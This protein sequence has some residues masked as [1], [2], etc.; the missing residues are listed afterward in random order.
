MYRGRTCLPVRHRGV[1]LGYVWLLDTDPG[2]S[3]RQLDG[4]HGGRGADR[5]AARRRGAAR[6]GPEPG[7]AG[8]ADRRAGAGSGTW[9]WRNCA[10]RWA[11]GRTPRTRWSVWRPG[12]Q[13]TRTTRPRCVRCRGRRP[14]AR[15]R[16]GPRPCHSRCWSGCAPAHVP[17]PATAA[18][19]RLLERA[20]GPFRRGRAG[21]RRGGC[22]RAPHGSRGPG[23]GLGGGVGGRPGGAR[24][25]TPR[26]GRALDVDRGVPPAHR[27]APDS[28]TTPPSARCSAPA[29]RELARTAEVYLDCAGQAG[30]TAAELGVHRQTLYY[31]LSRVE[32]L[33]GLDL[34]DGEDR[35]LLHMALKAQRL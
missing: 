12:P 31:R 16:G 25:A 6:R 18:A 23:H 7:A 13:P 14:C 10:T 15:C 3:E 30:R 35:L 19:G 9:R 1:V 27:A 20:G 34:D 8:G 32:P 21:R 33:T 26:A 17:T 11:P 2:P 4:G 29:H 28:A 5:R 22:V 24:G